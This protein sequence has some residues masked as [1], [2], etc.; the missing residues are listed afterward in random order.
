[1]DETTGNKVIGGFFGCFGIAFVGIFVLI[2]TIWALIGFGIFKVG[3][4][5]HEDGA[6]KVIER[7]WEGPENEQPKEETDE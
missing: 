3:K 6:E 5:V 2:I 1:M 4:A 7:V